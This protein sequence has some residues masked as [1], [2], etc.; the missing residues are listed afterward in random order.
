MNL[1]Y[2]QTHSLHDLLLVLF[3]HPMNLHYSQTVYLRLITQQRFYHPMNL[4]YSQTSNWFVVLRHYH[5]GKFKMINNII[6]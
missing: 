2:S 1:H 6:I 3:Y 4:H 5:A